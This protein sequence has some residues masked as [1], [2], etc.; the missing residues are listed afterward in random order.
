MKRFVPAAA[1]VLAA[2]VL[3]SSC[4][5]G[6]GKVTA[7]KPAGFWAGA[8]HGMVAPVSL[9][10]QVFKPSIRIYEPVNKGFWYDFGFWLTITSAVGGSGAAASRGRR[11]YRIS[12]DS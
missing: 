9:V 12:V 3:L 4:L 11:K 6:D 1:L 8:W 5:P 7:E 10:V 2:L